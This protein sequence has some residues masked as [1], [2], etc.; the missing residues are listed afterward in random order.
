MGVLVDVGSL[1]HSLRF[2]RPAFAGTALSGSLVPL[3]LSLVLIMAAMPS[4]SLA[5][6]LKIAIVEFDA[7]NQPAKA[8]GWGRYVA[9]ALTTAA[10]KSNA[11]DVVER[12]LLQKVMSE[13]LMGDRDKGFASEA[14]SVANMVGADY[15][16][17]GSVMKV[18]EQVHIDARLVDVASGAII[19]AQNIISSTNLKQ[20]AKKIDALMASLQE[21]VYGPGGGPVSGQG[22]PAAVPL[23][24]DVKMA[25]ADGLQIAL[26]EGDVLTAEDGYYLEVALG[27]KLYLYIGQVDAG[28]A[29]YALYPNPDFSPRA[30]PLS[31]GSGYRIP[32]DVNFHLD[33]NTGK[34]TIYA[35][36]A[37]GPVQE[38]ER[39]F[40]RLGTADPFAMEDLVAQF[41]EAV[42]KGAPEY[43][44][45]IWFRHE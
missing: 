21:N 18:D 29:L 13:Q 9:E 37:P 15:V 35:L 30:N 44:K 14:Q 41:Q 12:H 38:I 22:A 7:V 42:E 17:S 34:E 32:A 8:G 40:E 2:S 27:Q 39:V 6:P 33:E 24:L 26:R 11:F 23:V 4:A 3:L 28:G 1:W 36:A 43:K 19:S 16:L 45:V 25:A 10:V 5:A 20:L 31:P